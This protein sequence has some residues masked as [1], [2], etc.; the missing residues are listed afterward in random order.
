M[1]KILAI[2]ENGDLIGGGELSFIDL[3][4]WL[5]KSGYSV[6]ALVPSSGEVEK[7]LAAKGIRT[8]TF[9]LP[10]MR[11]WYIFAVVRALTG[12]MELCRRNNIDIIYANGTR[13]CLYWGCIGRILGIPVVWHC[14]IATR[15]PVRDFILCH[16]CS[17]VV[18]NSMATAN[19]FRC[20]KEKIRLVYNGLD[21]E[22]LRNPLDARPAGVPP[23]ADIILVLARVSRWKRHDLALR[24]FE[25][26]AAGDKHV[27]IYFVGDADRDDP[28]WRESLVRSGFMS[29]FFDRIH[30]IDAVDDIRPWLGVATVL[31]LPSDNEPFGR[32]IVESMAYGVPVVATSSGGVPEIVTDGVNGLLVPPGDADAMAESIRRVLKDPE[33]RRRLIDAGQ[34]RADDFSMEALVRNMTAV[35]NSL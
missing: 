11:P 12:G 19:R 34:K 18:A 16:L 9:H 33:L 14:R 23:D 10:K 7:R 6:F 21:I 24:A 17:C 3:A 5:G 35:F 2:S 29:V 22:W 13:A 26:I 28:G 8:E 30:W 27:H 25:R 1:K 15:E 31:L 4:A 20:R 32:V